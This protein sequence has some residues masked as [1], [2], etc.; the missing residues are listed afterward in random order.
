VL[1]LFLSR[2]VDLLQLITHGGKRALLNGLFSMA[3]PST[4]ACT[5]PQQQQQKERQ[6]LNR[7]V[8]CSAAYEIACNAVTKVF[9]SALYRN[10]HNISTAAAAAEGVTLASALQHSNDIS[11]LL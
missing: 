4:V 11:V 9:G 6:Q 7:C 3:L 10:L 8:W 1:L 5:T 2:L